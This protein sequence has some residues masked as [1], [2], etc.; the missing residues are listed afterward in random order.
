MQ[1]K[2]EDIAELASRFALVQ[3]LHG[4][5]HTTSPL[6]TVAARESEL[7]AYVTRRVSEVSGC[8]HE[9]SVPCCCSGGRP[10]DEDWRLWMH[11]KDGGRRALD[12]ADAAQATR[13]ADAV[14]T[15][16]AIHGLPRPVRSRASRH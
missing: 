6:P 4:G 2:V 8:L 9:C 13:F 16:R 14:R 11:T 5:Q 3:W 1:F 10:G 15:V 7:F 12:F